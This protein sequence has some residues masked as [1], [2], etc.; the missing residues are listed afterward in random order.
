MDLLLAGDIGATRARFALYDTSGT[1]LVRQEI[2]SSQQHKTFEAVLSRFLDGG[3]ERDRVVA[4]SFGIAGPVVDQRVKTTNLPWS[5]DARAVAR[6]LRI[7]SVHLLNDLVA[8]GLGSMATAPRKLHPVHL[9]RPKP[10]GHTVVVIAAGTGLGE[11]AFVWDGERHVPCP[12]EGAHVDFAPRNALQVELWT[13]LAKKLGHVSYEDV[14]AGS[15]VQVVYDFLRARGAR[16]TKANLATLEAA[17][18]RNVAIVEMA[19]DGASEVAMRALD[20]WAA[21]YGSEAG[22][23][24]L[25]YLAT[26]G[27]YVCGGVS[28]RL[29]EVL[30][31]GFAARRGGKSR[32]AGRAG[33]AGRAARAGSA[34]S[35]ARRGGR[36]GQASTSP[37]VDAFLTKGRMAAL[38]AKIPV[39][40]V[41]EPLAGLLGA[42]HD[43]RASHEDARAL[44]AG[45]QRGSVA[46]R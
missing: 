9:G 1:R 44:G 12:S 45:R 42:V 35:A 43:A 19:S 27:V 24:A 8:I 3:P 6:R 15:T 32:Q 22:N 11:A 17:Q 26:G 13:H 16:E 4:A 2:L 18:D 21:V 39:A 28:T 33:S 36:G 30:A 5:I 10:K 38:V 20:L 23:L 31:T 25:K 29:A 40:V 7:P 14:A 34:G 41:K 37:F 46:S